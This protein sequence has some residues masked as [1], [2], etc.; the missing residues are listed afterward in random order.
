MVA[1]CSTVYHNTPCSDPV[2]YPVTPRGGKVI[3]HDDPSSERVRRYQ[4]REPLL[5]GVK[6]SGSGEDWLIMWYEDQPGTIT[7]HY[8]G[9]QLV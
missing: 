3:G 1:D 2:Q 8:L 7:V 4:Y 9:P 5:W 6:V